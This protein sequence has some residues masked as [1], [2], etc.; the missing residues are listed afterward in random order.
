MLRHLSGLLEPFRCWHY[1]RQSN[2]VRRLS[3]V[4]EECFCQ[5][6]CGIKH[7]IA[8][9]LQGLSS[10]NCINIA[11]LPSERLLQL[12]LIYQGQFCMQLD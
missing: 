2:A 8:Y 1:S 3:A 9:C 11:H 10:K 4:I 5:I 7:V 12:S 6:I